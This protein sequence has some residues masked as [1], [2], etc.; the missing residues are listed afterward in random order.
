MNT[1]IAFLRGINVGGKNR[2]PMKD[3]KIALESVGLSQ[4]QTYIQTG[5]VVFSHANAKPSKLAASIADAIES[6]HGFRP[7][8]MVLSLAD[9]HAAADGNPFGNG[10]ALDKTLHLYFLK[11]SPTAPDF[12]RID[13][14][15]ADTESYKLKGQVFYFHTPGGFGKSKLVQRV[16][17][18]LGVAATA[19]NWRTV[20]KVLEL[21][22]T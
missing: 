18:L 3:L 7:G 13:A 9:L 17:A 6:G 15:K 19:R 11:A 16:E 21:A 14:L 10:E 2:L 8:V 4:I 20:T 1:W 12:A 22:G 5:N